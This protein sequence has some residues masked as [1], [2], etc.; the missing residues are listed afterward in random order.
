MADAPLNQTEL[1]ALRSL[2]TP[3]VCNALELVAPARRAT[4]FTVQP[5]VCAYPDLPPIVGY[6]C[7]ATI[8]STRPSGQSP[9]EAR[10]K[11][12]VY[13]EHVAAGPGPRIVVIED[14]DTAGIGFGA[15]WG[16]VQTT[17]HKGLGCI[18]CITNGSVRDIP[19][20]APGFQMI[21]GSIA[22][23]HAWVHLVEIGG[24]VNVHGMMVKPGDLVHAD[25]H[26][27][28]VIP[29]DVARKVPEAAGLCMRREAVILEAARKPGFNVDI[30]RK[31]LASADEIH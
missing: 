15:F 31:A 23:S 9:D 21:A 24:T 29:H 8:R 22:P 4:G 26:G 17:V 27:A 16:E 3:T 25:R 2:D 13:Y 7:T 12:I 10:K 11:R 6:A 20:A 18:G 28:V 14:V 1:D 19:Q 30:L 5:L